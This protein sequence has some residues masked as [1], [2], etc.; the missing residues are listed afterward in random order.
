MNDCS[1]VPYP[2]S[3]AYGHWSC[4]RRALH[5]GHHRFRNYTVCRVPKVWRIK[6]LAERRQIRREWARRFPGQPDS[7]LSFRQVL[8][9]SKY[10]PM[11]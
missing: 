2:G 6:R 5:L 11:S 4:E 10:E 7:P 9:P 3:G 1:F 8:Y